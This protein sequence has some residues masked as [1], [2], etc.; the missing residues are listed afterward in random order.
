MV[1]RLVVF[2]VAVT[3][4]EYAL[5]WTIAHLGI[6]LLGVCG[7]WLWASWNGKRRA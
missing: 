7:W 3:I 4:V 5:V 2:L 1:A 6:V